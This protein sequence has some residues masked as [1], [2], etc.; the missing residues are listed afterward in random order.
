[1]RRS[2]RGGVIV[3]AALVF[4]LVFV[5]ISGL[6]DLGFWAYENAQVANAARDGARVAMLD[7]VTTS[8]ATT[9]DGSFSSSDVL[10]SGS[11]QQL[12]QAAIASHLAGRAFTA[13]VACYAAGTTTPVSGGCANAAPGTDEVTVTV[14]TARP[15]YSFIGPRFGSSAITETSTLVIVGEPQSMAAATTTTS[16]GATTTTTAGCP[17]MTVTSPTSASPFTIR[18]NTSGTLTITGTNFSSGVS[19][20]S[21]GFS[22]ASVTSV[23]SAQITVSVSAVNSKNTYSLIVTNSCGAS[24]SSAG[25][26]VVGS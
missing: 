19:V 21:G 1:V 2:E 10:A 18:Q 14:T 4:P 6:I 15:S 8:P 24:V 16:V 23:T 12:V 11:A 17:T 9:A 3:E 13:S 7:Y 22:S 5:L 25:A 26:V 20:S